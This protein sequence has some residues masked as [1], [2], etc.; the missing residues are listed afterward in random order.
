MLRIYINEQYIDI[1]DQFSKINLKLKS[2]FLSKTV[3]Y[4]FPFSVPNNDHNKSIF[5][6]QAFNQN[7][8]TLS[9]FNARIIF[10]SFVLDGYV[11]ITKPPTDKLELYFT[12]WESLSYNNIEKV[13]LTELPYETQ[14]YAT[15]LYNAGFTKNDIYTWFPI[16]VSTDGNI[17]VVEHNDYDLVMM[18]YRDENDMLAGTVWARGTPTGN[19]ADNFNN[20]ISINAPFYF[21]S[22]VVEKVFE[23][24]GVNVEQN[25]I[26]EDSDF[27]DLVVVYAPTKIV[28]LTDTYTTSYISF[29]HNLPQI[30]IK[31]F[32]E[33][34]ENFFACKIVLDPFKRSVKIVFAKDII[35]ETDK[36]D[37]TEKVS[38]QP[39]LSGISPTNIRLK[40]KFY[41]EDK[42]MLDTDFPDV[43]EDNSAEREEKIETE[44]TSSIQ[45]LIEGVILDSDFKLP[46]SYWIW[47]YRSFYAPRIGYDTNSEGYQLRAFSDLPFRLLFW[48]V[49]E[50]YERYKYDNGSKVGLTEQDWPVG[51]Y[52]KNKSLKWEDSGNGIYELYYKDYLFWLN[53]FAKEVTF[54]ARFTSSD[55]AYFDFI[56]KYRIDN[57]DVLIEEIPVS[58]YKDRI[59]VGE[60]KAVTV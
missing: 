34:I 60:I 10:E 29:E 41:S 31:K 23:W 59:E 12:G 46:E 28:G 27:E 37:I 19:A 5:E 33:F 13:L 21:F 45:Q 6:L 17:G 20:V 44:G 50:E 57:I 15:D 53:N 39:V 9:Y 36:T 25:D 48:D 8:S 32:F 14:Y 40:Q 47:T 42:F 2:P 54:N 49:Q 18:N 24:L 52:S 11:K 22:Y 3:A 7:F 56:K 38:T 16:D 26:A 58:I 1:G 30:S 51:K 43:Y 35:K 4:T 55:L